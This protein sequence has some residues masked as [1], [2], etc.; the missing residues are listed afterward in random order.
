MGRRKYMSKRWPDN[1]V[2]VGQPYQGAP[3]LFWRLSWSTN[4][5]WLADTQQYAVPTLNQTIPHAAVSPVGRQEPMCWRSILSLTSLASV[6]LSVPLTQWVVELE[7]LGPKRDIPLPMIF[8]KQ[9]TPLLSGHFRPEG[10]KRS[11]CVNRRRIWEL[12]LT[13]LGQERICM[14]LKWVTAA[15]PA[16]YLSHGNCEWTSAAILTWEENG[17]QGLIL[18]RNEFGSNQLANDWGQTEVG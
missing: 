5:A 11:H 15:I 1:L 17:E 12:L 8:M 9:T 2:V 7:V 4:S 10:K 3:C 14:D 16:P 6:V 18:L 13:Q